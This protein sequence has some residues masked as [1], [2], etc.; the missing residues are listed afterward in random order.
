MSNDVNNQNKSNRYSAH[1]VNVLVSLY[2]TSKSKYNT[3][4]NLGL[5][6]ILAPSTLASIKKDIKTNPGG[7]PLIYK[8]FLSE[9][10]SCEHDIV[11]QLMM[12]EIKLR[13]GIAFNVHNN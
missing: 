6:S 1:V 2:L 4:R 5:L 11:G 9:S 10:K 3:L 13:N 7:D 8:S 12:D